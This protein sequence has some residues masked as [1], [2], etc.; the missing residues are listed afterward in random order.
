MLD[1]LEDNSILLGMIHNFIPGRAQNSSF[2]KNNPE[3]HRKGI[4][5]GLKTRL[6]HMLPQ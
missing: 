3:H 6:S 1:I 4:S 2:Q 5:S